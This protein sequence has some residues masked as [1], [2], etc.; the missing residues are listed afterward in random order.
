MA[1][2]WFKLSVAAA[3]F[4]ADATPELLELGLGRTVLNER[5]VRASFIFTPVFSME[6]FDVDDAA[7]SC[8]G[9][10]V[11]ASPRRAGIRVIG[12]AEFLLSVRAV[13]DRKSVFPK[14]SAERAA[15]PLGSVEAAASVRTLFPGLGFAF[16]ADAF[17][18]SCPPRL[19]EDSGDAAGREDR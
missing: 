1:G 7:D 3:L 6:V 11:P 5:T 18:I 19:A 4:G 2:R 12:G 17:R 15:L 9:A 10:W 16:G 8:E 14:A 13:V